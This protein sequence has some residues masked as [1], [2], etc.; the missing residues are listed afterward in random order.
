MADSRDAR[1][2]DVTRSVSNCAFCCAA[3]WA[4]ASATGI[5]GFTSHAAV[6]AG[7]ADAP[8]SCTG[9]KAYDSARCR[10]HC[11]GACRQLMGPRT[12]G[13]DQGCG[14]RFRRSQSAKAAGWST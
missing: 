14:L 1:R 2:R 10:R 7:P 6:P 4:A 8:P 3:L 9:D 11:G 5:V 12:P 13:V